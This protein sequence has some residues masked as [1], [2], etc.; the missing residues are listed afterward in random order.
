VRRNALTVL[1][2]L[3]VV[4]CGPLGPST[5]RGPKSVVRDRN[6]TTARV[7]PSAV[8]PP[9]APVSCATPGP[10]RV[11]RSPASAPGPYGART[12][13]GSAAVA[14]TFDDGPDP[15]NTP[16]LLDV[17]KHCGAHATFCVNGVKVQRYP[18]VVRRIHAEGHALCNHTWQHIH[19]LGSYGQPRIRRDL[20][21][22]NNAIHAVVPDAA[23]SYF[24]APGGVWTDDYIKVA[25]DLGMTPIHWDVDP[26]DWQSSVYGTGPA[27]VSHIVRVLRDRVRPGS[28]VLSHDFRKPDTT[29]AY[30]LLLPW[31]QSRFTLV[32]LPAGGLSAH[33]GRLTRTVLN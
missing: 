10:V 2:V 16:L 28:I 32:A 24:R 33:P 1:L 13:T 25:A 29:E 18:E 30:R 20:T 31:L 8:P 23:I 27:M 4:G 6:P 5:A 7:P 21:E 17:L 3:A 26:S 22:T 12:G 9:G 14:L 15:V 11:A 19:Q